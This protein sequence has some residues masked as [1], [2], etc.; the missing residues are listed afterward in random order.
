MCICICITDATGDLSRESITAAILLR[1]VLRVV[2]PAPLRDFTRAFAGAAV[3]WLTAATSAQ[4]LSAALSSRAFSTALSLAN[5]H[6]FE[7]EKIA[8]TAKKTPQ[9][10]QK[11]A[12]MTPKTALGGAPES[13]L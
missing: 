2:D 3:V 13:I 6:F 12:K 1:E 4:A 8:R 5:I 11:L 9:G 10:K 7:A